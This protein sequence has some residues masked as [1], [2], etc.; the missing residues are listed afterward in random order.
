MH[1]PPAKLVS[2]SYKT[3]S[4]H[5]FAQNTTWRDKSGNW[6]AVSTIWKTKTPRSLS[7]QQVRIANRTV[8]PE[9]T[10][11]L[12]PCLPT[13][14]PH[15]SADALKYQKCC[16][17][18]ILVKSLMQLW[19][20]QGHFQIDHMVVPSREWL[21]AAHAHDIDVQLSELS[22]LIESL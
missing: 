20:P 18:T 9:N 21:S 19:Q 22:E 6:T 7:L 2:T 1:H 8:D 5:S 14:K 12:S 13:V 16:V 15:N 3:K 17:G 11:S 4:S 10:S